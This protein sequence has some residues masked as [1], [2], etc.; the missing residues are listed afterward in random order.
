MSALAVDDLNHALRN[1]LMIIRGHTHHLQRALLHQPALT[2]AQSGELLRDLA[3]I[4]L[5]VSA[6]VAVLDGLDQPSLTGLE[7]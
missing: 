6:L 5:A 7:P 2:A 1:P 3:G 4:D